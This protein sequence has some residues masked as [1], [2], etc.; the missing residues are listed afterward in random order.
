MRIDE[1]HRKWFIGAAAALL[2]ATAIYIPYS[3]TAP[4]GASGGTAAGIIYG[5]IASAC[6]L[7][8]GLLGARKKVPVWR[9]GRAQSWMRGHLWLGFIS[10]P[11]ILFHSGFRFGVGLTRALMWLFAVVFVSGIVG[12]ILQHFMPR[13]TTQRIPLETIY[14][15][16]G[17]VRSQLVAE[18]QT[19]VGEASATLD[20]NVSQATEQQRAASAS[21]GTIG[22]LTVASGLQLDEGASLQLQEFFRREMQPYIA[23]GGARGMALAD[24]NRSQSMF[25]QLRLLLPP[26]LHPAVD[27]L[28]NICEEKRELDQQ[29]QYHRILHGWLLVHI[30]ASYALLLLGAVH[31]VM[32]LRY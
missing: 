1:T 27:D 32:A 31:A 30:P 5:S 15:Q 22:G 25:Q 10:F 11:L 19:L 29:T 7:F 8:A 12:A 2:V 14:E 3:R 9:V 24:R 20:G 28:E 23:H 17:R 16:I 21:A 26:N 18:A 13:L 6:M 4:Q